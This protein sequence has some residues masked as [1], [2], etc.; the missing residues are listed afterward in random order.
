MIWKFD[1]KDQ[2]DDI[3]I[4]SFYAIFMFNMNQDASWCVCHAAEHVS[5]SEHTPGSSGLILLTLAWASH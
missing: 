5:V 3:K 2:S 4:I 1:K